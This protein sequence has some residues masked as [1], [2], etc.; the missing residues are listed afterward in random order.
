MKCD[1]CDFAEWLRTKK[2]RLHPNKEGR[3]TRLKEHPLDLRLPAAFRW[4]TLRSQ[5]APGGG[6]IK[7]G[8]EIGKCAFRSVTP[9][10]D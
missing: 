1:G 3:C 7:R 6:H 9:K 10:G 4:V 5:P 8:E 2:G